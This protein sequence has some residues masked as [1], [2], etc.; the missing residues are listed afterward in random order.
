MIGAAEHLSV[1]PL[2]L[3]DGIS[4]VHATVHQQLYLAVVSAHH[5]DRLPSDRPQAEVTGVGDLTGVADI[6]P[7]PGEDLV[8]LFLKDGRVRIHPPVHT[9]VLDERVVINPGSCGSHTSLLLWGPQR[10]REE[11]NRMAFF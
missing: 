2:D 10:S 1:A 5:D 6:D 7:T 4:P 3:A 9:V 11:R 8:H